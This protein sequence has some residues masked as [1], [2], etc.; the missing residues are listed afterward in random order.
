MHN[1]TC[2]HCGQRLPEMSSV[3]RS[4]E[5]RHLSHGQEAYGHLDSIEPVDADTV[6]AVIEGQELFLPASLVLPAGRIGV[7]RIG[8]EFRVRRLEPCTQ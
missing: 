4:T 5:S 8:D 6:L 3:H 1:N 7:L 2:P